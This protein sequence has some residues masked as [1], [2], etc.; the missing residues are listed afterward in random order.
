MMNKLEE[1]YHVKQYQHIYR[2][3]EVFVDWLE[4]KDF[5]R[6]GGAKQDIRYGLWSRC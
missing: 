3:T 2:S 1:E 4:N 5:L 6:G